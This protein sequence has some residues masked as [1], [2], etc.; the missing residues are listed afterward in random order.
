MYV[1]S[2]AALLSYLCYSVMHSVIIAVIVE[3]LGGSVIYAGAFS[4]DELFVISCFCF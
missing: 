1:I 4:Y 2:L 3:G